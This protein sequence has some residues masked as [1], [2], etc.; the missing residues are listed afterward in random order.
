MYKMNVQNIKNFQNLDFQTTY[1]LKNTDYEFYVGKEDKL[2]YKITIIIPIYNNELIQRTLISIE[3]QSFGMENIE[4]LMINDA[5]TD[6]TPIIL[7]DYADKFSNFKVIHI[8]K[9]TGSSGTPRNIGIKEASANYVMFIDHDDFFEIN[10]IEKLYDKIVKNKCDFVYG[11]YVKVEKNI[12]TKFVYPKEKHGFFKNLEDNP[13]SLKTPPSI[14]TKLFRRDFLL[15]NNIFFPTILGED[16]IFMSKALKYA[17]GVY[18]L[19]DTTICYYNLNE[20]SFST[21]LP[22]KYFLEG[23]TSEE[24]LYNLY[25]NWEHPE[26]YKIRGQGMVDFYIKQFMKSNLTENEIKEI[27]PLF[28]DFCERIDSFNLEP[29]ETQTSKNIFNLVLKK[30]VDKLIELKMYNP[31]K[32]R[33]AVKRT[34]DKFKKY[35]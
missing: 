34:L 27:F 31:S 19:W 18:Y 20:K 10:A 22:A 25:A 35:W 29:L 26:Y 13:N 7:N 17:N 14:W 21:S 9:R 8:T 24:Y 28:Y 6:N 1:K 5:S 30:D 2:N 11:T 16:A 3:N 32:A 23:F 4:V 12:P 33:L 15:E